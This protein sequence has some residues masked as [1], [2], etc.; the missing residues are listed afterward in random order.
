MDCMESPN[1]CWERLDLRPEHPEKETGKIRRRLKDYDGFLL[2][3][4][5]VQHSIN[6]PNI[7][8]DCQLGLNAFA[9]A[10]WEIGKEK[11]S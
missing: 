10:C 11:A 9:R 3:P 8:P 5:K 1:I 2:V 7:C 6:N 4:R